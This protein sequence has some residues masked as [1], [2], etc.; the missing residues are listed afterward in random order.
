SFATIGHPCSRSSSAYFSL[1]KSNK[2]ALRAPEMCDSTAL[3]RLGLANVR[4][5]PWSPSADRCHP[6][7]KNPTTGVTGRTTQKCLT[8]AT[9]LR[10]LARAPPVVDM[11]KTFLKDQCLSDQRLPKEDS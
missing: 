7:R 1:A 9:A 4:R 3:D 5:Y 10:K 2:A 11:L 6:L 8:G